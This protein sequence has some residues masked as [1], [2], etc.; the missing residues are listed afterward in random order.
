MADIFADVLESLREPGTSR[1]SA[2]GVA[3]ILGVSSRIWPNWQA[4]T[5]TPC[6]PTP[7]RPACNP[8]CAT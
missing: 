1:L 5:A 3:S 2:P 6:A 7:N 8:R 4:S